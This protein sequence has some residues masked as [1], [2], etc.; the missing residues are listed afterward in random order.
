M[1]KLMFNCGLKDEKVLTI[2]REKECTAKT[3]TL[4]RQRAWH[5]EELKEIQFA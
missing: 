2:S 5:I 1:E 4:Y 3:K